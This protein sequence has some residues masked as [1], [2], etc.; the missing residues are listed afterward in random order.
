MPGIM[1]AEDAAK[2]YG[3]GGYSAEEAAEVGMPPGGP[4]CVMAGTAPCGP[5]KEAI[6]DSVVMAIW[7][8]PTAEVGAD[9][10]GGGPAPDPVYMAWRM[11]SGMVCLERRSIPWRTDR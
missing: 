11:G 2:P 8:L 1:P 3:C 4:M 9:A 6:M 7:G 5:A 10:A